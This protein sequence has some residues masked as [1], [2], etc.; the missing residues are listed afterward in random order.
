[1]VTWD[2]PLEADRNGNIIMYIVMYMNLNR[3]GDEQISSSIA[4]RESSFTALQ[5]Y[6]EYS[7]RVAA[8]TNVGMG[9]FSV[10]SS[11]FTFEDGECI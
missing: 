9:P 7:F 11:V 6:E 3:S 10:P 2:D 8:V 1:M 4:E 5:E